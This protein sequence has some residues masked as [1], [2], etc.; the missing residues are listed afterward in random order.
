MQSICDSGLEVLKKKS[1]NQSNNPT[2]LLFP[3]YIGEPRQRELSN[4][5]KVTYNS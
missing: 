3:H 5:S 1:F 4:L 2:L